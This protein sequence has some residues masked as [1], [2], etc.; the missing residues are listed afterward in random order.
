MQQRTG[1]PDR[2]EVERHWDQVCIGL[3]AIG[4]AV[5]AAVFLISGIAEERTGPIELTEAVKYAGGAILTGGFA[6]MVVRVHR[7]IFPGAVPQQDRHSRKERDSRG[8]TDILGTMVLGLLAWVIIL[9]FIP[10]DK[11]LSG[12]TSKSVRVSEAT[13]ERLEDLVGP[14]GTADEKVGRLLETA[15]ETGKTDGKKHGRGLRRD[16]GRVE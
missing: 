10:P 15:G 3:T 9:A 2:S 7:T 6:F 8:V 5:I 13:W 14:E 4:T 16:R 11:P 1:S 12:D